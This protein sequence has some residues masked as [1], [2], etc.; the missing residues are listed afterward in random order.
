METQTHT[1]AGKY[2]DLLTLFS[3]PSGKHTQRLDVG[4]VDVEVTAAVC[5]MLTG[6]NGISYMTRIVAKDDEPIDGFSALPMI[7]ATIE[8]SQSDMDGYTATLRFNKQE[9]PFTPY[10]PQRPYAAFLFRVDT[11]ESRVSARF[12]IALKIK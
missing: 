11:D 7:A 9:A 5:R 2:A 8:F 3:G 12:E 6:L 10:D 4:I 1:F